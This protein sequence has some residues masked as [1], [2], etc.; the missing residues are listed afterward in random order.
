M[1]LWWYCSHKS[2]TTEKELSSELL[3][4]MIWLNKGTGHQPQWHCVIG[5]PWTYLLISC[6]LSRVW[7]ILPLNIGNVSDP[8]E[9]YT[10]FLTAGS[11]G[12]QDVQTNCI[13]ISD[14]LGSTDQQQKYGNWKSYSVNRSRTKLS[15]LK[16][17]SFLAKT[18]KEKANRWDNRL[19]LKNRKTGWSINRA[20]RHVVF[21][22]L[23]TLLLAFITNE[24]F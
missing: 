14:K 15:S 18:I 6:N 2:A 7:S 10:W 11:V 8:R 9:M 4:V 1:I 21:C 23:S 5:N 17:A 19:Q 3:C 22:W 24:I 16:R 20:R 12:V 13:V